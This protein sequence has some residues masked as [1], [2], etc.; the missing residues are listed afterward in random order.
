M[1][2]FRELH[3]GKTLSQT[4]FNIGSLINLSKSLH[5]NVLFQ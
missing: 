5:S 2:C 3:Q 1:M 4:N